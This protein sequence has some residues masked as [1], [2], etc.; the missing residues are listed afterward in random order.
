MTADAS[1]AAESGREAPAQTPKQAA[2]M[3]ETSPNRTGEEMIRPGRA[4]A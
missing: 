2:L 4:A 3:K 1:P